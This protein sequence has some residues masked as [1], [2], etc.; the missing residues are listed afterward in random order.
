MQFIFQ[1]SE[2]PFQLFPEQVHVWAK[3]AKKDIK[4]ARKR[5]RVSSIYIYIFGS[6]PELLDPWVDSQGL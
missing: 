6:V 5:A 4:C 1:I 2:Y 3:K